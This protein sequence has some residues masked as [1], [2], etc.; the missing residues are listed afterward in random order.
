GFILNDCPL[1]MET[2]CVLKL[3]AIFTVTSIEKFEPTHPCVLGV[4]VYQATPFDPL[5]FVRVWPNTDNCAPLAV[6]PE[7]APA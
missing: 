3:A 7:I 6:L 5:V 1:H 2:F 4:T